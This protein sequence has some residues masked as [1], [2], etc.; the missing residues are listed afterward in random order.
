MVLEERGT[1]AELRQLV[2]HR[3]LFELIQFVVDF[4]TSVK[5]RVNQEKSK[6]AA[7]N[8]KEK[9]IAVLHGWLDANIDRYC[10]DLDGCAEAAKSVDGLGR[11]FDWIRKEITKYRKGR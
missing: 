9:A 3:S 10:G 5:A 1:E 7:N 4:H 8:A 11:G 6:I 2:T